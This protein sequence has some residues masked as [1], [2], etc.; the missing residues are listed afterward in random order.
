[1]FKHEYVTLVDVMGSD[2]RVCESARVSFAKKTELDEDSNLKES[3][4]KLIN[5]LAS[6]GHISPFFHPMITLRIK[7]PIFVARQWFKSQIGFARNETSRRY[8]SDAPEFW[9]PTEWRKAATDKKQGSSDEVLEYPDKNVLDEDYQRIIGLSS[10]IYD[11][12]IN[13]LG[14]SPEQARMLLPQ[15]MMTEFIETSSLAAYARLVKLRT[16]PDAQAEIRDY[17]HAVSEI[18]CELFPVSWKAL[19]EN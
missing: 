2:L 17:A 4:K 11:F 3:D 16:T 15:S 6:H 19:M 13:K 8:V 14:T 5:Y 10:E 12:A 18:M 7:M 9:T 1:M